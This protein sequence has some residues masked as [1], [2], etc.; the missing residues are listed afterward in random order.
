MPRSKKMNTEEVMG[1][2]EAPGTSELSPSSEAPVV[3]EVTLRGEAKEI[4]ETLPFRPAT[5]AK[6]PRNK[7][8]FLR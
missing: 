6:R 4:Q 8:K 2:T 7:P 5:R 3:E 1:N